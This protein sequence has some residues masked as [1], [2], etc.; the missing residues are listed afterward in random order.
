MDIEK[1]KKD[2]DRMASQL[3]IAGTSQ[4]EGVHARVLGDAWYALRNGVVAIEQLQADNKR[5]K[6]GISDMVIAMQGKKG[7][8]SCKD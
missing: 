4:A 5:L 7:G 8:D 1:L 2:M 3:F 6:D